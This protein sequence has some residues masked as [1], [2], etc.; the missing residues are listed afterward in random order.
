LAEYLVLRTEELLDENNTVR[1]RMIYYYEHYTIFNDMFFW[2]TE[3][4]KVAA[5]AEICLELDVFPGI[6]EFVFSE[7]EEQPCLMSI[8]FVKP[9]D[10]WE[11]AQSR[12]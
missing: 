12:D 4:R 10:I 7:E 2:E 6:Y 5:P 9:G 1:E 3:P 11:E 8:R